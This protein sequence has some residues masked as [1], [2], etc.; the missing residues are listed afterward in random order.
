MPAPGPERHRPS[1]LLVARAV[2]AGRKLLDK[3]ASDLVQDALLEA[4]RDAASF[5]GQTAEEQFAWLR[6]ILLHNFLD[7]CARAR[8]AKYDV[9]RKTLEADL[10][11]SFAGL[12]E[13]LVAPDTSP[14][15][16]AARNEELA[17][18]ADALERLESE[19]Q[20]QAITLRH[21]AGLSLR[22]IGE[23]MDLAPTAVAGL[24]YRG[25]QRLE[26]LLGPK[27]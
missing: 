1:L 14:S 4:H 13:L 6:K 17:R 9:G 3:D 18:L 27:P 19:Q 11:G 8:A 20:R 5:A 22:E 24:L 7:A 16:R 25:R 23:R 10:T 12:D 2:L 26:E 15:E 21:V